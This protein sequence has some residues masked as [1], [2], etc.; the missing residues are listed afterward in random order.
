MH[1]SGE[2]IVTASLILILS[3]IFLRLRITECHLKILGLKSEKLNEVTWRTERAPR[4]ST[5]RTQR[6]RGSRSSRDKLVQDIQNNL[7][8]DDMLSLTDHLKQSE[9]RTKNVTSTRHQEKLDKLRK[10]QNKIFRPSSTTNNKQRWVH[11]LSSKT[12][13]E[14]QVNVLQKGFKFAIAPSQLPTLDFVIGVEFGLRQVE[15]LAQVMTA[16]HRRSQK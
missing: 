7:S 9:I 12:L 8:E 6:A 1:S 3:L 13:S 16:R 10:K 2:V 15:D 14:S 5:S 4:P 11:N